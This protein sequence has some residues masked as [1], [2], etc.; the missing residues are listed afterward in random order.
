[1]YLVFMKL[2]SHE[3]NSLTFDFLKWHESL[4]DRDKT[5]VA[6]TY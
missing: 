2:S 1:M 4:L 6:S 5:L 3:Y